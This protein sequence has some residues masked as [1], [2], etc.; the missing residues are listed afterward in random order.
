MD[1]SEIWKSL[2]TITRGY[3]SL[4]VVT[5]AACALEVSAAEERAL[6][7]HTCTTCT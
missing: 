2:P 7:G 6:T 4:C 1:P 5:T 3:V